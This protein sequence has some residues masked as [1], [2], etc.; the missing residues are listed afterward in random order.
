MLSGTEGAVK[1]TAERYRALR[2]SHRASR[3][4]A[5]ESRL[6]ARR[7]SNLA[8]HIDVS[9]S[10]PRA[11]FFAIFPR[12]ADVQRKRDQKRAGPVP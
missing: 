7:I 10:N 8:A 3:I 9:P 1:E 11:M 6:S 4:R 2:H 12:S 5:T